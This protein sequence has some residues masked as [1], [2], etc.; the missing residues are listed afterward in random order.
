MEQAPDTGTPPTQLPVIEVVG[1]QAYQ[2]E[3]WRICGPP[4]AGPAGR[5]HWHSEA[6]LEPEPENPHDPNAVRVVIGERTVGYLAR[7]LAARVQPALRRRV[8][9]RAPV[10]VPC[11]ATGGFLFRDQTRA[12]VGLRLR[13]DPETLIAADSA[14]RDS[15]AA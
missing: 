5:A 14:A 10:T 3:I 6:A 2:D 4:T 8:A 1:T 15:R 11:Y 7:D 9:R 12:S 13:F